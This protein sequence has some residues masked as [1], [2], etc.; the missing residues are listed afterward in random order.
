MIRME[1]ACAASG[2]MVL[3]LSIMEDKMLPVVEDLIV[4][5]IKLLDLVNPSQHP[6]LPLLQLPL[7]QLP[8]LQLPHLQLPLL[9]LPLLQHP[10]LRP[11]LLAKLLQPK[12][13]TIMNAAKNMA[14]TIIRR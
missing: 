4:Q 3:T 7:L 12:T 5:R 14:Q 8:H 11:V 2:E 1:M 13:V 9:Q 6:H 10:L